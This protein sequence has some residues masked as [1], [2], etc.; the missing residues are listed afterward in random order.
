MTKFI[1]IEPALKIVRNFETANLVGALRAVGLTDGETDHGMITKHLGIVVYEFGL[2]KPPEYQVYTVIDFRLYAGNAVV[3][4]VDDV[5]ETIDAM[6][7]H[8]FATCC[9]FL[10]GQREVERAIQMGAV[11]RPQM[12]VG[13]DLI[14]QWPAPAPQGIGR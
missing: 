5:G 3:Y 9:L 6:A 13:E 2:F 4:A 10:R 11:R 14:W 12:S 7:A 1:L 8:A